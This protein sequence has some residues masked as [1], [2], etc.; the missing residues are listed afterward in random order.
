MREHFREFEMVTGT[1]R[2]IMGPSSFGIRARKP[3][4]L[5]RKAGR[6][7]GDRTGRL[8]VMHKKGAYRDVKQ[9]KRLQAWTLEAKSPMVS[10]MR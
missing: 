8:R 10:L 7:G 5:P 4:R 3:Q 6:K 9:V 2:F 1:T